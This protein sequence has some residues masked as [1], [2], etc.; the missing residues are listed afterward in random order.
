MFRF[1]HASMIIAPL[2]LAALVA[3][4]EGSSDAPGV[5]SGG[6]VAGEIADAAETAQD[7]AADQ[8]AALKSEMESGI[9]GVNDQI[10]ALRAKADDAAAT[11]KTQIEAAIA[12]LETQRDALMAQLEDAADTTGDAWGDVQSGLSDAWDSL[13]SAADDAVERFDGE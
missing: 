10:A 2:A 3:C 9:D 4:E 5:T 8:Y 7:F 11:T 6:D 1:K 13:K 12:S